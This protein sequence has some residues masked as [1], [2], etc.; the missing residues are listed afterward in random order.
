MLIRMENDNLSNS[1]MLQ[2]STNILSFEN[3]L[4]INCYC[5]FVNIYCSQNLNL[6][7]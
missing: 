5:T 7:H 6:K 2:V 3:H 1:G 4:S